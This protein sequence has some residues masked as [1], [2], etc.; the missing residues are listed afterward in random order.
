V[1]VGYTGMIAYTTWTSIII[2]TTSRHRQQ[3]HQLSWLQIRHN[4][5]FSVVTSKPSQSISA[6]TTLTSQFGN[7]PPNMEQ[8]F[9]D[10]FQWPN[11]NVFQKKNEEIEHIAFFTMPWSS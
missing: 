5:L 7:N 11:W 4:Y 6:L 2:D 3:L 10:T 8:S 9:W 1:V